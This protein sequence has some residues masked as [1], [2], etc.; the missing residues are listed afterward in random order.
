MTRPE[1]ARC[2]LR[3]RW[4][5]RVVAAAGVSRGKSAR[6]VQRTGRRRRRALA[7][8][9]AG[10]RGNKLGEDGGAG[11]PSD[12]RLDGGKARDGSSGLRL[13]RGD[14][15]HHGST[16]R[17]G[18]NAHFPGNLAGGN[19][20]H[21]EH[22]VVARGP[23]DDDS[24]RDAHGPRGLPRQ[25][26]VV[27]DL[28]LGGKR[29]VGVHD[30]TTLASAAARG[31]TSAFVVAVVET[32]VPHTGARVTTV[33]GG[34]VRVDDRGLVERDGAVDGAEGGH[35]GEGGERTRKLSR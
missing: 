1:C 10:H 17:V 29:G 31:A 14:A 2:V 20:N 6:R 22:V 35:G 8:V 28:G 9:D 4:R 32:A 5:R 33:Q 23:S 18:R 13:Q 27:G 19:R 12:E 24:G 34:P 21:F 3:T 25:R 16:H 11:H 15:A 7:R 26:S 30:A